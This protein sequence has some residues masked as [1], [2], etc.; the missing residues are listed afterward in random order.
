MASITPRK[1]KSG[2]VISYT[3]RVFRGYDTDGKS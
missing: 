3:I 2:N 1:D